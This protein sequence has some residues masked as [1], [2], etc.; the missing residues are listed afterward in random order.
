[1]TNIVDL[2]R[3]LFTIG[4]EMFV[5]ISLILFGLTAILLLIVWR[6]EPELIIDKPL[7]PNPQP[8][9]KLDKDL[10]ILKENNNLLSKPT[11][12]FKP[13][14]IT[15]TA[16]FEF[17]DLKLEGRE[18]EMIAFLTDYLTMHID[19]ATNEIER[20]KDNPED[21]K[22]HEGSIDLAKGILNALIEKEQ[23]DNPVLSELESR[24]NDELIDMSL[25][26]LMSEADVEKLVQLTERELI[27]NPTI[28]DDEIEFQDFIE[29]KILEIDPEKYGIY[30]IGSIVKVNENLLIG[31][32]YGGI[33]FEESMAEYRGRTSMIN[34]LDLE[35]NDDIPYFKLSI[36]IEDH[37]W[38]NEML[39][40]LQNP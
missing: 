34:N 1:M 9:P 26:K 17:K 15:K 29:R 7:N 33:I 31:E 4:T 2:V 5:T 36:D 8:I 38:S 35:I 14:P 28:L 3:T 21:V 25:D 27:M 19:R 37:T 16:K 20:V 40:V 11:T 32:R 10:I 23:S 6:F 18:P 22:Y 13:I 12:A 24:I 30:H 39:T